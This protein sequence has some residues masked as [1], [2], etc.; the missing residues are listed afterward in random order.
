MGDDPS[1]DFL[2]NGRR[3]PRNVPSG[4]RPRFSW[5]IADPEW[6]ASQNAYRLRVRSNED[7][8]TVWDSGRT[9]SGRSVGVPYDGPALE[10]DTTYRWE[11]EVWNDA[12]EHVVSAPEPFATAP[13]LADAGEWIAHLP[14][15]GDTNGYRSEWRPASDHEEWVQV[16]LERPRLID[17]ITLYPAE[18]WDGPTTPD[19]RVITARDTEP[20]YF[21]AT[22]AAGPIAFGFPERYRI[23][24]SNDPTFADATT[25]VDRSDGPGP[26][27]RRGPVNFVGEVEAR[28]LR[29]TA[30]ELSAYG[31]RDGPHEHSEPWGVFALAGMAVRDSAGTDLAD[32]CSVT[33]SSSVEAGHWGAAHLTNGATSSV[34]ASRSP[35]LRQTF[36]V[37]KPVERAR[38]HV[39]G[40]GYGE[41]HLNG[42]RVGARVLDPAWTDYDERVLYATYDVTDRI[43]SGENAIGLWLGRGWFGKSAREW[44]AFGSPRA[45]LALR[46]E[47]VDGSTR[48]VTTDG[49]WRA[50]ASPIIANDIYDGETYDAR[51]EQ[52]GW[53]T[54]A[55][56]DTT[57]DRV[58]TVPGPGGEVRPQQAPPMRVTEELAPAEIT[59]YGDALIVDFGQNHTGW[60]DLTVEGAD[61][62]T[63]ITIEYAEARS[64]HGDLSTVDLR[65]ADAT[66]RYVTAGRERETYRPRFTSHGYRYVK[67][68]GY[69]GR[70]SADDVRSLVVHSDLPRNGTF[71]SSNETL[72]RIQENAA[73]G[74]RS[75]VQGIITDCPQRDE[76]LGFSGDGHLAAKALHYNFDAVPF[77]GK[78]IR[79]HA[80]A[81][82]PAGYLP[83]T[84]PTASDPGKTDP[85]W[86]YSWLALARLQYRFGGTE[87]AMRDHYA[88]LK[89]YVDYWSSLA[90][91][92]LI[93]ERY[94]VYGDWVA[95]EHTDGSIGEPTHLFTNAYYARTLAELAEIASIIGRDDDAGG[96]ERLS[97]AAAAAFNDRYLDRS[98]E[99]YGPGTQAANAVPLAL[100]LVPAEHTGGVAASLA[101][102]VRAAGGTLRTGF[103]GTP[104]LLQAL[105]DHGYSD[106]AYEVV[107]TRDFPGWGYQ[108]SQGATTVWERWDGDDRTDDGMNS[109]NHSPF[110]LVSEWFY[111]GLAG[112]RVVGGPSEDCRVEIA[113][114][115]VD[116]LDWI[117]A[118]TH[119]PEGYVHSAWRRTDAGVDLSVAIPWNVSA[120]LRVP[121][122]EVELIE[123]A[124]EPVIRDGSLIKE[125]TGTTPSIEGGE[126]DMLLT[127][128]TH[129][130]HLRMEPAA[131]GDAPTLPD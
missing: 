94:S 125:A 24:V 58:A 114:A 98:A 54:A 70:L 74:L 63:V 43:Q 108:V 29:V 19:G 82:T 49:S 118:S 97:A 100:E 47:F 66:D 85:T 61:P 68:T 76:R 12:G 83:V 106:L 71:E 78:F 101:R 56:D 9:A 14:E 131:T 28:Y 99:S 18:P 127:A 34:L 45:L 8:G 53:A 92:D 55:F 117:R 46:L 129:E 84:M 69:P 124:D 75:N 48:D 10:P 51:L 96:Y 50:T 81:Q 72:N 77:C 11:V 42:D 2:V 89:R 102:T 79:D 116:D 25:I 95:L 123:Y 39:V 52:A 15:P 113:P 93:P 119:L 31:E 27:P 4:E 26:D 21:A 1:T 112:I 115:F 16:D 87:G 86:T 126:F 5:G 37:S 111:E 65:T 17:T 32:G 67:L 35:L 91:D 44:T 3:R 121:M 40:L 7:E 107:S 6:G 130:F 23:E 64:A 13:D 41:C 36:E 110:T 90:V 60:V 104:A 59:R 105:T 120:T 80:D 88:G 30:L 122:D 62:G 22:V 128:G 109:R 38:L 73:W 103:L 57:W 33:A 20:T